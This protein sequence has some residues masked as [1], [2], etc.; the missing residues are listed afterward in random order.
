MME[1]TLHGASR[2]DC[3]GNEKQHE[4]AVSTVN[5]EGLYCTDTPVCPSFNA[6]SGATAQGITHSG[7]QQTDTSRC[8]SAIVMVCFEIA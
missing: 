3:M 2:C 5:N 6:R 8:D 7:P 4:E 1:I